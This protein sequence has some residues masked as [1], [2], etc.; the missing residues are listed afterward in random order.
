MSLE[1]LPNEPPE[2]TPGQRPPLPPSPSSGAP[3]L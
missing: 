1:K 3:Q 2:A